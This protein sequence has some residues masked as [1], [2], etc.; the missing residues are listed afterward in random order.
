ME[1]KKPTSM[2]ILLCRRT[3]I[4]CQQLHN[5]VTLY[6]RLGRYFYVLL[7][8]MLLCYMLLSFSLYLFFFYIPLW[9]GVYFKL[10]NYLS[11]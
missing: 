5:Y 8:C 4:C 3:Y 7:M 1:R 10:T 6:C 9:L 2:L 11:T